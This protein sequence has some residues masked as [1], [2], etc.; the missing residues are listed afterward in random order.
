MVYSM[1]RRPPQTLQI[2]FSLISLCSYCA[3]KTTFTTSLLMLADTGFHSGLA[4]GQNAP[5][6]VSGTS[7]TPSSS[8]G[9]EPPIS[10]VPPH[11]F[12]F[13]QRGH[14]S[15]IHRFL[16]FA[17]LSVIT[18]GCCSISIPQCGQFISI[19]LFPTPLVPIHSQ[20]SPCA[21]RSPAKEPGNQSL[22]ARCSFTGT[23]VQ[24]QFP[25]PGS[26]NAPLGNGSPT[27]TVT[28]S[29]SVQ[30]LQ[31]IICDFQ[32]WRSIP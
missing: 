9:Y 32:V 15:L 7:C 19:L 14:H 24:S 31:A 30:A 4:I 26:H 20:R 28:P 6:Q 1:M 5:Q 21:S 22:H 29:L 10:S 23:V 8:S 3:F 18:L 25:C 12:G 11:D 17:G 27:R 13:L 16:T 2:L